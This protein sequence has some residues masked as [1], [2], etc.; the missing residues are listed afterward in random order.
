M[1]AIEIAALILLGV[2]IAILFKIYKD[3]TRWKDD[4][5]I[6]GTILDRTVLQLVNNRIHS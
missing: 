6:L 5:N 1:N 3:E 2:F 4:N